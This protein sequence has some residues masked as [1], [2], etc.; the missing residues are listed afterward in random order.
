MLAVPPAA[1][2]RAA[3]ADDGD[4]LIAPLSAH[5]STGPA[6]NFR[7]IFVAGSGLTV[8]YV[9]TAWFKATRA[10]NTRMHITYFDTNNRMYRQHNSALS[11][12]CRFDNSWRVTKGYPITAKTGRVCGT[13]SENG[14][15]K[16]GACVSIF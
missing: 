9:Q 10:C 14:V 13:V 15:K 1:T 8:K 7:T 6:D 12:G 3:T 5:G 4:E 11:T 16:P 2:A